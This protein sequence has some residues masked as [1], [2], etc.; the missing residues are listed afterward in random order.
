MASFN[1]IAQYMNSLPPEGQPTGFGRA[2]SLTEL[3]RQHRWANPNEPVS[4]WKICERHEHSQATR[5]R[6]LWMNMY[7]MRGVGVKPAVKDRAR[8]FGQNLVGRYDLM[9]LGEVWDQD[10]R[11]ESPHQK[12]EYED[13]D[14]VIDLNENVRSAVAGTNLETFFKEEESDLSR[15]LTAW[16]LAGRRYPLV[17]FGDLENEFDDHRASGLVTLLDSPLSHIPRPYQEPQRH[18][19][20]AESKD[21]TPLLELDYPVVDSYASKSVILVE[22]A[23][24]RMGTAQ[25]LG[26]DWYYTHLDAEGAQI[27]QLA[28]LRNFIS[29]TH[30]PENV[31]ILVGDFNID[32]NDRQE[33]YEL[34]SNIELQKSPSRRRAT[35]RDAWHANFGPG[36]TALLGDSNVKHME[37]AFVSDPIDRYLCS[38]PGTEPGD[39][40]RPVRID[41]CFIEDPHPDHISNVDITRL[42]RVRFPRRPD[43]PER[44]EVPLIS[45]H[46][47]LAFNLLV[48]PRQ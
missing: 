16:K 29:E 48:T 39:Q 12:F 20:N 19:Y 8:E 10:V 32:R 45:D 35:L 1:E 17:R 2:R 44:D 42:R 6:C 4:F 11:F 47:G 26:I 27:D 14:T 3:H 40:R 23:A 34:L 43:A 28:E 5:V 31:A 46:L 37:A 15:I 36:H 33:M 24:S 25:A 41:Y 30:K 38:E 9:C 22:L 13:A 21:F 7:M 18:S